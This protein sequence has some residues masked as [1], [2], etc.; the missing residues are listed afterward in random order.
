MLTLS[1]ALSEQT[2]LKTAE[3]ICIG[4]LN[5]LSCTDVRGLYRFVL[6]KIWKFTLFSDNSQT[7]LR[8]IIF[9]SQEDTNE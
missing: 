9:C 1:E 2:L 3:I 5:L 4:L 7:D 6:S 8:E